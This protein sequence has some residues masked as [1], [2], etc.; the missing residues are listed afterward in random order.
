MCFG[1]VAV[2][3]ND[4]K[5]CNQISDKFFK[6]MCISDLAKNKDD[7]QEIKDDKTL[8]FCYDAVESRAKN[9]K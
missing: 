9:I 2:E 1:F 4:V 6:G 8:N 5:I 3:K 7:C